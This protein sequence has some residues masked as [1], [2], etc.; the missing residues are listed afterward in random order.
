MRH[1][2]SWLSAILLAAP[3]VALADGGVKVDTVGVTAKILYEA[4]LEGYLKELNGKYKLRVTS[5][6]IAPG[7]HVGSHHHRGPGIRQMTGGEMDY[8]LPDR[9]VKYRAGDFFFEAGDVSH[10]VENRS[11]QPCTHLLF[12]ILPLDVSGPSLIPVPPP[13]P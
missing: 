6:T 1:H 13:S 8:I 11:T 2:A 12:E 3:A 5:I 10:H 4:P 9:T 7:G